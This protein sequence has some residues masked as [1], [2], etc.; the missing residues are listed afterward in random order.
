MVTFFANSHPDALANMDSAYG[1]IMKRVI[2]FAYLEESSIEVPKLKE[3]VSVGVSGD[4]RKKIV[5]YLK[6]L[7]LLDNRVE[8]RKVKLKAARYVMISGE[9]YLR[10]LFKPY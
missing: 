10:S 2:S 7:E 3:V 4:L 6:R 8:A 1:T 5:D 9:L